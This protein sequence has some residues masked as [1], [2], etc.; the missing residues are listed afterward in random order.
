[1]TVLDVE[2]PY[3]LLDLLLYVATSVMAAVLMCV[4]ASYFAA[5]MP[6][7]ILSVWGESS[8]LSQL[9]LLTMISVLQKYY[10]STSRKIRL[11]DLEAK[12]PLYNHLIE[13]HSGLV[14]LRAFGWTPNFQE[15]NLTLLDASQKPYYLLLCIQ[16]W[17][18]LILDL[19]VAALAV[20]LMVLVVKLRS[21]ISSPFLVFLNYKSVLTLVHSPHVYNKRYT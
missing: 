18:G 6:P 3:S 17:L 10:L 12:S 4:S 21:D 8:Q 11:L 19:L 14:T 7:V 15:L 5:T 13:S 20:I 16:H 9:H 1:M 2:L